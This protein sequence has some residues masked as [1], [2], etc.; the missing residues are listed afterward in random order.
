MTAWK[1]LEHTRPNVT[2]KMLKLFYSL[3]CSL[4]AGLRWILGGTEQNFQGEETGPGEQ[5]GRHCRQ[6]KNDLVQEL[7]NVDVKKQAT[8]LACTDKSVAKIWQGGRGKQSIW[9]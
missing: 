9:R 7:Q 6:R 2:K 4:R 1:H 3:S 8:I 5:S